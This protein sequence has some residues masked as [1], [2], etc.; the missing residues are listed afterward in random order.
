MN[1]LKILYFICRKLS[2][3][4]Q[5]L[6]LSLGQRGGVLQINIREK[7]ILNVSFSSGD[8]SKKIVVNLSA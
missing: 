8:L 4:W 5:K 6:A 7:Y 2:I 3:F 1:F